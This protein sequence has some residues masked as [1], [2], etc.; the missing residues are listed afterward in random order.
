MNLGNNKIA[1][2][3]LGSSQVQSAWLG[4]QIVWTRESPPAQPRGVCFTA[5]QANSSVKLYKY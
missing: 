3:V 2:L 1:D 4:N 5:Q